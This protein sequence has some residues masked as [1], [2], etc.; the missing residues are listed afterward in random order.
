M[1]APHSA[2]TWA[3]RHALS[4]F[5]ELQLSA[6]Q[7]LRVRISKSAGAI[8]SP[9]QHIALVGDVDECL[10]VR[11]LGPDAAADTTVTAGVCHIKPG[12]AHDHPASSRTVHIQLLASTQLL[13]RLH[14]G[15]IMAAHPEATDVFVTGLQVQHCKARWQLSCRSPSSC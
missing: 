12:A 15:E 2:H 10:T 9:R 8:G 11:Q 1:L 13:L 7:V 5:F 14:D 6:Y 4:P 3:G